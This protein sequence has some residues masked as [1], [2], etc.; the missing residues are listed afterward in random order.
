M[1]HFKLS[2][3]VLFWMSLF[4]FFFSFPIK[5]EEVV[6]E[7]FVDKQTVALDDQLVLTI[8][9]KG[10]ADTSSP[11]IS[12]R[13]NFDV[14]SQGFAPSMR[15][16][17]GV[18]SVSKEYTY[19]LAP[20]ATGKFQIGPITVKSNGQEYK[21]GPLE[22]TVTQRTLY[23]L[24]PLP[25]GAPFPGMPNQNPALPAL[26]SNPSG[27]ASP[28]N[29]K[30]VFATAE[31]DNS[32]PYVGQQI[33]YQFRV[34]TNKN[35]ANGK[36]EL[37]DF[38]DFQAEEIQKGRSF[39]QEMGG[40]KYQ[41]NEFSIILIPKIPGQQVIEPTTIKGDVEEMDD[42]SSAFSDPFFTMRHS[43]AKPRILKTQEV[44]VQVRELPANAPSG[45]KGLVGNFRLESGISTQALSTGETATLTLK[46]SGD[47]NFQ[48]AQLAET[49]QL[50][51]AK[52][53][54]DK[55][56]VDLQKNLSGLSG[57]KSFGFAI[58]PEVPGRLKIPSLSIVYFDPK[59]ETYET[60]RSQE[61]EIQ[62]TPSTQ[63]ENLAKIQATQQGGKIVD[64]LAEDIASIHRGPLHQ[65]TLSPYFFKTMILVFTLPPI[66]TALTLLIR[67]R[68]RWVSENGDYLR[69]KQALSH[70]IGEIRKMDLSKKSE[71][72]KNLSAIL[73]GYLGDKFSKV[74]KALTPVEVEILL[75]QGSFGKQAGRGMREFLEMLDSWIYG[76]LPREEGWEKNAKSQAIEILKE[77]DHQRGMG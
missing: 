59:K 51:G 44:N 35:M 9:I 67:R 45:F 37:P 76:E 31:V 72:P 23:Q 43:I 61:V 42:L 11:E 14:L 29:R 32:T 19:I 24:P 49:F 64:A 60:L 16:V 57:T 13:G 73:K 2:R 27:Q 75:E 66:V 25:K 28:A 65:Q 62:V 63:Q 52:I 47:G 36:F 5:A 53:Y 48:D 50:A 20:R 7:S 18:V 46:L 40:G 71:I 22:V 3:Q 77:I 21:T 54:E 17:N 74:G 10:A 55:P 56:S 34:Y 70:A 4:L 26:P 38:K 69:K 68:R 39:V 15:V 30:D 12:S 58:V 41:V 33:L 6:L 8:R 1:P